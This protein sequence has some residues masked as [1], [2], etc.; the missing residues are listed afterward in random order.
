MEWISDLLNRE[1]IPNKFTLDMGQLIKEAREDKRMS[2]A[3]LAET[4]YKR[5]AS[6]SEMEN[7]KM[8]PDIVS[9]LLMAHHLDKP[10]MYFIPSFARNVPTPNELSEGEGELLI[11]FRRIQR[12][13]Q[14]R[15]AIRQVRSIA[16]FENP[17]ECS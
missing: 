5:R 14:R 16:D 4:I 7:G 12:E 6:L 3:E 9:L 1:E 11:Q 13:A 8:I 10:L 15:L 2:Q 17:T